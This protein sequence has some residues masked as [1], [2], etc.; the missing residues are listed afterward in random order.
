MPEGLALV[1]AAAVAIV[2]LMVGAWLLSLALRDASVVDTFWGLGFVLVAGVAL[3]I[4][5]GVIARRVLLFGLVTVWGLRLAVHV[6]RRNR[7]K[8]EDFRYRAFRT[9]W[10]SRFWWV[11]LFTVFLLQGAIMFVV[12]APIQAAGAARTPTA[13]GALDVLGAGVWLVGFLFETVGDLQLSRFKANPANRGKV[14]DRG[15]WRYTRH[16]NYFGDATLWWGIGLIALAVPWGWVAL[17]GPAVMT[18]MLVR[19]SGVA[20]L[21]RTIGERRPAYAEYVRKT[22]AF[23]PRPPKRAGADAAEP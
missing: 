7:G 11:S 17:V 23:V 2:G 19:V 14:M 9:R 18:F 8:G 20:M 1:A 13:L 4:G 21:E 22:S 16:P 10:G 3:A 6:F 15:L 12:S 5:P